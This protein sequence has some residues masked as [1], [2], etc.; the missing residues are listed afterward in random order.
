MLVSATLTLAVGLVAEPARRDGLSLWAA[1]L[2]AHTLAY[3]L[4]ALRGV[5][6]DV[7]TVVLPNGLLSVAFACF[8][9]ALCRF[10]AR[11]P[12]R[13]LLWLPVAVSLL[14]FALL[15]NVLPARLVAGPLIFGAQILTLLVLILRA[16]G[17]TVGRGQYFLFG[18]LAAL[19][20]V[21]GLNAFAALRG[22]VAMAD[23]EARTVLQTLA[24][25]TAMAS[26]VLCTLGYVLMCKEAADHQNQR[27][28]MIDELTGLP[29]RR[30]ALQGLAQQLAA[31]HRGHQPLTV[32]MLDVDHFK[33]VNDQHGHLVGDA[34]LRHVVNSLRTRL[35]GQDLLGRLGGEEFLVLLP[36][37]A[38]TPGGLALA[39]ELRAVVAG[40][41]LHGEGLP[42]I[43]LAVSIGVADI[44]PG[45]QVGMQAALIAADR[46]LYRAKAAGR[47]RVELARPADFALAPGASR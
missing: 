46:A 12:D 30:W 5:A 24:F 23:F 31:A 40:A 37:T 43:W 28:A 32:M 9:E 3:G 29:N 47:N 4:L 26:T 11:R 34:A 17:A 33:R 21:L 25:L 14:S 8:G 10:H 2:V 1:G 15:M 42:G 7:L 13:R 18:G 38:A 41:S 19:L 44:A 20:P 27:L 22:D 39:E 36:A 35:R 6:H 45:Q 16:R